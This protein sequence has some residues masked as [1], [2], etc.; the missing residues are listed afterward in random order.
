MMETNLSIE[1]MMKEIIEEI[2]NRNK[3]LRHLCE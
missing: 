3:K 2:D 1:E